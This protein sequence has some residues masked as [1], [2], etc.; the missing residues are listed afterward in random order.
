[1]SIF[2]TKSAILLTAGVLPSNYEFHIG[3]FSP[4]SQELILSALQPFSEQLKATPEED[5]VYLASEIDKLFRN[6]N[7]CKSDPRAQIIRD[8][9]IESGYHL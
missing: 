4:E 6:I 2:N 7:T 8:F 9:I 5:L 3:L 1:M